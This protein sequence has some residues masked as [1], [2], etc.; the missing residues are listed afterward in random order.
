MVNSNSSLSAFEQSLGALFRLTHQKV[1][2]MPEIDR[3][4]RYPF[5]ADI[6]K[7][8]EC[9]KSVGNSLLE[10]VSGFMFES[11]QDK[12]RYLHLRLSLSPTSKEFQSVFPD[13]IP[14]MGNRIRMFLGGS[15]A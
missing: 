15:R 11:K 14:L 4:W 13:T 9:L 7:M 5:L 6:S 12:D 2:F 8:V 3:I 10:K 1:V